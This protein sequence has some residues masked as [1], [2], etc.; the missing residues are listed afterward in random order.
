MSERLVFIIVAVIAATIIGVAALIA[1]HA[2]SQNNCA[3]MCGKRGVVHFSESTTS[4]R[5]T[6]DCGEA[7]P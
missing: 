5:A 6:C 2:D 7:A 3:A 4:Y 1:E